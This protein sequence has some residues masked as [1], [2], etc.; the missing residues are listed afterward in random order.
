MG[1]SGSYSVSGTIPARPSGAGDL[2]ILLYSNVSSQGKGV[3]T[4]FTKVELKP[5]TKNIFMFKPNG[6]AKQGLTGTYDETNGIVSV[7]GTSSDTWS[8]INQLVDQHLDA[9]VYT[10]GTEVTSGSIYGSNIDFRMANA[11]GGT[12]TTY[13]FPPEKAV[14][15]MV[16]MAEAF[17]NRVYIGTI[18]GNTYNL[19][20]KVS[21]EK[22]YNR[23]LD[24]KPNLI[25]ISAL[26][27]GTV[28]G[29]TYTTSSEG[30]IRITGTATAN[31]HIKMPFKLPSGMVGK[32]VSMYY[33]GKI[34]G[35]G[36]LALKNN[37]SNI[38]GVETLTT[39]YRG[40]SFKVTDAVNTSITYFDFY[41]TSGSVVDADFKF[42][43][44]EGSLASDF[45]PP[46][47]TKAH[48]L[49]KIYASVNGATKLIYTE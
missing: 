26:G 17:K 38:S 14:A 25:D 7:T 36:N 47:Q 12:I 33:D 16:N 2:A 27:S 43:V 48:R 3:Y 6:S 41:F 39:A 8:D 31:G 34:T 5:D 35:A 24:S 45:T 13:Y 9:G 11:S 46:V 4:D 42:Y 37:T 18:S 1:N 23:E 20:M 19:K 15:A 30:A 29:L 32:V 49:R 44:K 40:R 10:F 22:Q 28:S 21:L